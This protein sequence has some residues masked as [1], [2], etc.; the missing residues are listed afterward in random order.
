MALHTP[1]N[2]NNTTQQSAQQSAPQGTTASRSSYGTPNFG[3]TS[4][5]AGMGS[6]GE[7]YEKLFTKIQA[8]LKV[9]NEQK[10][11]EEKYGVHKLLKTTAGLNYSGIVVTESRS[12]IVAANVLMIE[13][14][15]NYPEKLVETY[16]QVRYDIL[17]T[18]G[19]ALDPKYISQTIACISNA[20]KVPASSIVIADGTLVPN[21]FDAES[22]SQVSELI[23]NTLNATHVEIATRVYNYKGNDI[24]GIVK[25]FPTGR[26]VINLHF[27]NEDAVYLDQTGMPVRQDI[28]VALSF[29]TNTNNSSKSINQG[30][31]TIEIVR[32]YG[33]IDFE[34][35][36]SSMVNG[37]MSTQKFLPNFIITH[38]ESPSV[39]PTPDLVML[40]VASVMSINEDM[41]WMQ[42]FRPTPARKNEVDFNDIGAL[43]VEGNIEQNP[44]GYGKKYDTK[45]KTP[46]AMELNKLIQTLVHPFLLVS[47]DVPKAGPETWFTSV[48]QHIMANT[49][50][51]ADATRRVMEFMVNAT[52]GAYV[53]QPDAMFSETTNKIH[54]GF[55][56][57]KDGFRDLRNL[58]CYLAVANHVSETNQQPLLLK[59]YTGTLYDTL[60][61]GLRAAT[62]RTYIEP[63][64]NGASNVFVKQ[65]Y[66]RMTFNS[67]F[68][69]GWIGTLRSVGFMP[70]FSSAG[71]VNDLFVKRSTA[72][73]QSAMMGQDVRLMSQQSSMP[74]NWGHYGDYNRQ[75]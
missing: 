68:L 13:R 10:N 11:T 2:G 74:G 35:T 75:F 4:Q 37:M 14:T 9:L 7:A 52:G 58:S 47:I 33:Y 12:D 70:V 6:G 34:Y 44:T 18:P 62:R 46:N 41:A 43:N 16:N 51:S 48:F 8:Q 53:P 29:K 24:P 49:N 1:N 42:A 36:N 69:A 71:S 15:G 32:T 39:A 57:V 67:K 61:V 50:N 23:N 30:D 60:P 73:F 54:G 40:S 64:A 22:D 5:L 3:L 26:F 59:Q 72:N 20:L 65:M 66:E 25:Q 19:E 63:M 55:Y 56:K 38:I 27:N 21:E 28:C 45:S 17:R 31:D